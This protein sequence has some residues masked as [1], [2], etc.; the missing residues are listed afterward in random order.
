MRP[1]GAEEKGT[2]SLMQKSRFVAPF[3]SN[4]PCNRAS[5]RHSAAQSSGILSHL[6]DASMETRESFST[7]L[8]TEST[9][10]LSFLPGVHLWYI[11]GPAN[12]DHR[13]MTSDRVNA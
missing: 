13:A 10:A 7:G 8:V 11:S 5:D 9:P 6:R 1:T 3:Y 4:A 12:R 2:E